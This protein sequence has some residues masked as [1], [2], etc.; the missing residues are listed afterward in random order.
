M[1]GSDVKLSGRRSEVSEKDL[2][3]MEYAQLL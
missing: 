1:F 2:S 3:E